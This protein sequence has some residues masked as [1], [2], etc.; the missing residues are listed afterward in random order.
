MLAATPPIERSR[1]KLAPDL[2]RAHHGACCTGYLA[3]ESGRG[4]LADMAVE[5]AVACF[6]QLPP[7][8]L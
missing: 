8:Y 5:D 2:Q 7:I 6:M 1:L 3:A 4:L